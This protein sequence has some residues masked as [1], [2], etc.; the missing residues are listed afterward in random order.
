MTDVPDIA[1]TE[2]AIIE[3]TNAFRKEN[4]LQEVQRN[5]ALAAAARAFAKYLASNG[6]F[7]HTADGK[8]PADRAKKAGY[9][10][11]QVAE[12]LA[13]HQD[14]DGFA[15]KVLAQKAVEGWENSPGHRRNLL[16]PYVTEVG[17]G[18]AKAPDKD[19]KYI[20]VQLFGRPKSLA[21]EFKITNA[22]PEVVAYAFSAK[23]HEIK[24]SF[25]VTHTSCQPGQIKFERFGSGKKAKALSAQ[26]QAV[27]GQTY[28]LK[29]DKT[30]GVRIEVAL[31]P[32]AK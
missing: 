16:A 19:P 27:N 28:T 12:N 29:P 23:E 2:A 8:Q 22:T 7:S 14:S 31:Q 5:P 20:S 15:T 30:S 3:L 1:K 9:D 24:P 21:Y 10:Y 6:A 26:Y 4:K 13:L 17:V 25:A 18:V 32:K 11:C